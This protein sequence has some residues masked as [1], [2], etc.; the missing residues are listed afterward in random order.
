MLALKFLIVPRHVGTVFSVIV[1]LL[2]AILHGLHSSLVPSRKSVFT[3]PIPHEL[4]AKFPQRFCKVWD[5]GLIALLGERPLNAVISSKESLNQ[6]AVTH[7][8]G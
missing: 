1:G 3:D 2:H 5:I 4:L 8:V 7:G 6:A